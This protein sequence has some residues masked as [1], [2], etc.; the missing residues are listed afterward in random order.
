MMAILSAKY[1]AL[2]ALIAALLLAHPAAAAPGDP[3]QGEAIYTLRCLGCHGEEGDGMG[4]GAERLNPPPRDFTMGLYKFRTTG[5]DDYVPND[6]DLLR[7]IRDGMPGTAMPGWSDVLS[8]ADMR[9][10]IAYL[11]VFG[12][13]EE[14]VPTD[15]VDYGVQVAASEDSIAK[16]RELF[17]DRCDECHGESGKG[18]AT[19]RLKD[20]GGARTWPRNL[21]KP[22]TFRASNDARDIFTRISVGIPGT[23]MPSYA[24]PRSKKILTIEE[25]WHVANYVHSLAGTAQVVRPENTVVK[26]D[27]ID[28]DLPSSPDDPKWAESEP[29]TFYLVPQIIAKERFFT[30]SNDTITVR[31]LYNDA[32]LAILLEWDDRTRSLPGD[33]GAETVAGPGLSEDAVAVQ[34]PVTIPEGM[35]KPYFGMGDAA[36]PVNI[37]HW[38]SG[39]AGGPESVRLLDA[40]GFGDFQERPAEESWLSA[41]GVYDAGTWRVVMARPLSTAAVGRDIQFEEGRFTPIAFAAWD[42]SNGE[43]GSKHT[44]TTWYWLLLK[45]PTG[46]RPYLV[47]LAVMILIAGAQIWW[48]R[49]AAR[50]RREPET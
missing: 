48:A 29:S 14:E 17:R 49:G 13:L 38:R 21:T 36:H 25:R 47:A 50:R 23:Q 12:G 27:R 5:F 24:D 11:K 44:M 30:P 10:L 39:S 20:D 3:D 46:P 33:P 41:A 43:G 28:G 40:R 32:A 31:A 35:R 22:W 9:D 6:E 1:P 7:M 42:G 19:K 8:G 16:G 4:P 34:L 45:P 15:Q 2:M 18:V 37:W 26:A